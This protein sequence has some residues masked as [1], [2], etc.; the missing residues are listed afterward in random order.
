MNRKILLSMSRLIS[1]CWRVP[2]SPIGLWLAF[3]RV[4]VHIGGQVGT[5]R[6]CGSLANGHAAAQP[7][8]NQ[9]SFASVNKKRQ[10]RK[11]D[12]STRV[13]PGKNQFKRKPVKGPADACCCRYPIHNDCWRN[14]RFFLNRLIL[15]RNAPRSRICLNHGEGSL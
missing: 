9:E 7:K 1:A 13:F 12:T 4:V 15:D 6:F 10:C 11:P 5:H 2:I 8:L 3:K 14:R